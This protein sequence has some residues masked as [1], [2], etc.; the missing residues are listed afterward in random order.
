MTPDEMK[1]LI[2]FARQHNVTYIEYK[3]FKAQLGDLPLS[4]QYAIIEGDDDL[5]PEPPQSEEY[6]KE[7]AKK[8][9]KK[10]LFNL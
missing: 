2:L 10:D 1:D 3:D 7:L 4:P 6:R 5:G 9:L 8:Q